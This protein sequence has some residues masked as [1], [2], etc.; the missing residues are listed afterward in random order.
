MQLKYYFLH[1]ILHKSF[2][3]T[4]DNDSPLEKKCCLLVFLFRSRILWSR[5]CF[6]VFLSALCLHSLMGIRLCWDWFKVMGCNS[7]IGVGF[8]FLCFAAVISLI[9]T[10]MCVCILALYKVCFI[11]SDFSKRKLRVVK[12]SSVFFL[13]WKSI[14]S[15]TTV[16]LWQMMLNSYVGWVV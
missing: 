15:L 8:L 11:S 5:T 6:I 12:M 1:W 14:K 3:F 7:F 2:K 4:T 10:S 9:M 16:Q 13:I